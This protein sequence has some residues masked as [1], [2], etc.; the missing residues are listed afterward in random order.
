M[1][2]EFFDV[3]IVGAGLSG[4]GAAC[5]LKDKCPERTFVI[6]EGRENIGGTWDLFRYPGVRSDS[7]MYT[8]SYSFKPWDSEELIPSGETIL[9]YILEASKENKIENHIRTNHKILKAE[10]EDKGSLWK[11]TVE[12]HT[13]FYCK[14]L[15]LCSGYYRYDKGHEP[16][17]KGSEVFRGP[18]I[19]AQKWPRDLE[20]QGKNIAVIGSGATAVTLVPELSKNAKKVTMIQRSP[21]YIASWPGE[22]WLANILRKFFPAR[23][24]SFIMKTKYNIFQQFI[25]YFAQK[26]PDKAK[27]FLLS[28][29]KKEVG[30]KIDAEKHFVPNYDPWDQRLCLAKDGDFF[31]VLK[32]G[33][34]SIVTDHIDSFYEN[35]IKLKSG[36]KVQA[37]LIILATGLELLPFG[38]MELFVNSEK[39]D[40][41]KSYTYKGTGI[42]NVPNFLSVFGYINAS[43]TLRADLISK[44]LCRLLNHLKSK[45]FKKCTPKLGEIGSVSRPFIDGFAPGFFKRSIH[46]FPKQGFK[47]PWINPQNYKIDKEMFLTDSL[48]DGVMDFD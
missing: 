20:V 26:T 30:P 18:L 11:V 32:D 7:D 40:F 19:H 16:N 13:T 27:S 34:A 24:I 4:I 33:K 5:H 23:L 42:S 6:L 10:W 44:Y 35:G 21:T 38:G 14:F 22:D 1:K 29:V 12:N 41:S 17:F 25:Y 46:L 36:E 48:D 28:R 15:Y 47:K 45:N 31:K 9:S 3:V 43:W 37:D 2:S 8:L 39:I